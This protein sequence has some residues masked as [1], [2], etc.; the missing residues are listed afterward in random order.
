MIHSNTGEVQ[1]NSRGNEGQE[2]EYASGVGVQGVFTAYVQS[3][4]TGFLKPSPYWSMVAGFW[5]S[6]PSNS[7]SSTSSF[8]SGSTRSWRGGS[9]A[10]SSTI[11]NG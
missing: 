1:P 7:V 4:Q 11:S 6:T 2:G 9:F 3:P 10:S 5:L 8:S